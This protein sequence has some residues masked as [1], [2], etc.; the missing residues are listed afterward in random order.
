MRKPQSFLPYF[1]FLLFLALCPR[2]QADSLLE[3]KMNQMR[4][5]F[6]ELKK[7]MVAPVEADK[8]QYLSWVADLKSAAEASKTLEPEKNSKIPADQKT[9]FLEGYSSKM[10]EL[11]EEIDSLGKAIEAG[12]WDEA[13]A[14]VGQI[15]QLQ[16][17][18]HQK[19]RTV[20]NGH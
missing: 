16:R 11:A 9:A 8:Q 12:K 5:S 13:K 1:A 14:L 3:T 17:E 18:G 2:L 19:Y 20:S 7:A 10:D 6:R 4:K 15:N